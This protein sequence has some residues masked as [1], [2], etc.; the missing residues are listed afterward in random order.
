MRKALSICQPIGFE[1]GRGQPL[2]GTQG[3]RVAAFALVTTAGPNR[4]LP[5]Q[6]R[7]NLAA[8]RTVKL[9]PAFL[10]RLIDKSCAIR[11]SGG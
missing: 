8:Q 6:P 1:S 5:D 7:V 4:L 9:L 10:I 3:K 2:S 11:M